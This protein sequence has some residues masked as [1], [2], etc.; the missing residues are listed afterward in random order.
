MNAL[1]LIE[2]DQPLGAGDAGAAIKTQARIHFGRDPPRNEGQN[3]ATKTHQQPVHQFIQGAAPE[4][5][6]GLQQ[7]RAVIG[8]LH[9]LEDQRRV[10]GGV[11]RLVGLNLF[12]V[13][14]IGHHGGEL[15]Q[16]IELVHAFIIRR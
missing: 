7:Q 3:L 10:G 2:L 16:G 15:F 6:H 12:E 1:S 14:A 8:L 4:A 11:L 9:R 5:R 13:A